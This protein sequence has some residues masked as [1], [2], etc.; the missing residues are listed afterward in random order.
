[1]GR[2]PLP[3]PG[4]HDAFGAEAPARRRTWRSS[5]C[6]MNIQHVVA[7]HSEAVDLKL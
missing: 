5:R 2:R 3:P 1:M 7:T 6:V 4:R